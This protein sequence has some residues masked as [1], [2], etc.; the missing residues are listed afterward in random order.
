[1]NPTLAERIAKLVAPHL[2]AKHKDTLSL[3]IA[4]QIIQEIKTEQSEIL[5]WDLK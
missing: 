1:M 3:E 5:K 2:R 4:N